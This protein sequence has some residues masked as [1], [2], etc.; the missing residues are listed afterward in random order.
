MT[1]SASPSLGNTADL[2]LWWVEMAKEAVGPAHV[3]D[4]EQLWSVVEGSAVVEIDGVETELGPGDTVVLPSGA[5]RRLRA[6]TDV[7]AV[8]CGVG[9]ATVSVPG[10]DGSRGTPP[11]I[12]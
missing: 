4:S 12:S 5:V 1:T 7:R 11:W 9:S 6:L 10:E 2:S 3:F 8:V